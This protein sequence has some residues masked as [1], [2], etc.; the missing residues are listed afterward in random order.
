MISKKL[1]QLDECLLKIDSDDAMLLSEL[2]GFIAGLIVGP[3]LIMPSEWLAEVWG[4]EEPVFEDEAQAGAVIDLIMEHYNNTIHDIE[5]GK[6]RPLYDADTMDESIMWETWIEGFWRA[7]QLRPDEWLDFSADGDPD[8]QK[9]I[10][11]LTRLYEIA[12]T[13]SK[14]L[15]SLEIDAD[16]D[17][18]APDLIPVAVEALDKIRRKK[19]RL[20][21]YP[22]NI[23]PVLPKTGRND[24]CPCGSGKK[25]KKCCLN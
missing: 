16:L 12:S 18:H 14:D 11:I 17:K 24:P 4:S 15:A 19:A 2:D 21:A 6:Y 20:D 7:V 25:F 8:L 23:P 22:G 1:R 10:F 9:E 5:R 13:P 3:E